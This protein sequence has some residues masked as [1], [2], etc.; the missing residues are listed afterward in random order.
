MGDG[1]WPGRVSSKIISQ[2]L[3]KL[4]VKGLPEMGGFGFS[5]FLSS[6]LPTVA[7]KA[8]CRPTT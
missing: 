8:S 3:L 4:F 7:H 1:R 5:L 2:E 6:N